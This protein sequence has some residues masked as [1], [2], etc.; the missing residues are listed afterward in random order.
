LLPSA[1][2]GIGLYLPI[3]PISLVKNSQ[4]HNMCGCSAFRI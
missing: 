2:S 3:A 4:P 1:Q